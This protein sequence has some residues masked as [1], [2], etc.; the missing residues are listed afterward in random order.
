MMKTS[1]S[2]AQ[3]AKA[4]SSEGKTSVFGHAVAVRESTILRRLGKAPLGSDSNVRRPITTVCPDV[5]A[6]KRF[7]SA[8]RR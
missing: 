2:G 3:A 6:L 4:S 5:K 7:K 1:S 8:E